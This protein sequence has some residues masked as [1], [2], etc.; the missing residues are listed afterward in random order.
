[1]AVFRKYLVELPKKDLLRQVAENVETDKEG[2]PAYDLCNRAVDELQEV[3]VGL[4]SKEQ[5]HE[6]RAAQTQKRRS[7]LKKKVFHGRTHQL[8]EDPKISRESYCWHDKIH[9]S[10]W[11]EKTMF[12]LRGEDLPTRSNTARW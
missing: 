6:L 10:T 3:E 12:A 11:L 4:G 8:F 9:I 2:F 7:T 5:K 1:M